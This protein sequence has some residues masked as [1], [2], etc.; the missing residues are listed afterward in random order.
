M[1]HTGRPNSLSPPGGERDRERG[2]VIQ[3]HIGLL[4]A[5]RP[6][7]LS[8]ALFLHSMEERE[9]PIR[10]TTDSVSPVFHPTN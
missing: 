5:G 10:A 3:L 9:K 4:N 6:F 8:P 7:L 1:E 2:S